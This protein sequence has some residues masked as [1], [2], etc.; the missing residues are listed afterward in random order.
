M[1]RARNVTHLYELR[2]RGVDVA[3]R[4]TFEAALRLG[5]CVLEGLGVGPFEA[6]E[7]ADRFRRHNA[8]MLEEMLP[9]AEN[10]DARMSV[11]RRARDQLEKMFEQDRAELEHGAH[12]WGGEPKEDESA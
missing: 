6:R 9:H 3:E 1:A 11:A 10:E 8:E 4:E 2:R 12:E 5:R 7:R